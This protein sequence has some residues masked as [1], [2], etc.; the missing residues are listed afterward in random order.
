MTCIRGESRYKWKWK[1]INSANVCRK[2]IY[3]NSRHFIRLDGKNSGNI[4][5]YLR[6]TTYFVIYKNLFPNE[7]RKSIRWS[8]FE[9]RS[10]NE[11][12]I[13]FC[14]PDHHSSPLITTLDFNFNVRINT[15]NTCFFWLIV[16][17]DCHFTW[18]RKRNIGNR[19]LVYFKKEKKK[20]VM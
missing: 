6:R 1:L 18:Y 15:S 5:F 3:A 14:S 16:S 2:L 4:S 11:D 7:S 10:I 19:R 12:E 17:N 9:R 20:A 8:V 13:Y